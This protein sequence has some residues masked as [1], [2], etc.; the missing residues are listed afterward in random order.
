MERSG[1]PWHGMISAT[2]TGMKLL[3]LALAAAVLLLAQKTGPRVIH[4]V[5]PK[6]TDEARQAKVS[7]AVL[8]R[9][10]I[11]SE[12][13]PADIRIVRKLGHGLDEKAVEALSQWRFDPATEDGKPV[14]VSANVE[15]NF[16]LTDNPPPQ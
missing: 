10:T 12:G 11:T 4:R 9:V 14:E 2:H 13:L 1:W 16:R 5:E 7:G 15:M 8:M 6:Y 3:T